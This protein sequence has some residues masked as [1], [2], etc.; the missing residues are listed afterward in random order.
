M[1]KSKRKESQDIIE[2]EII[3]KQRNWGLETNL[4]ENVNGGYGKMNLMTKL[5]AMMIGEK[6]FKFVK[7]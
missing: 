7:Q 2:K 6:I 1:R 5:Q 4:C 3:W